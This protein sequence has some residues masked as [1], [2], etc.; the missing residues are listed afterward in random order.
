MR[1]SAFTLLVYVDCHQAAAEVSNM[2]ADV[3]RQNPC[4]VVLMLMVPQ[5]SPPGL[6]A[7]LSAHCHLPVEGKRQICSEQIT[8]EARG[9]VGPELASVVVSLTLSALPIYLWWRAEDFAL[10]PYF[11]Q[12]LRV[13]EQV[14]VD[15][16]RFSATGVD[17]KRL[18]TWLGQHSGKVRLSDLN[19]AR[20]T[21]WRDVLAQCFDSLE[22]RPYLRRIQEVRFEYE[23][24]SPRFAVQRSQSLLLT[25]WLA[26]RLE[27][28]FQRAE[29]RGENLPRTLYFRSDAGEV[30]VE[31]ALRKV[32]GDACGACFSVVLAA[33][34]ARFSF[35]RGTDGK[36]V[37]TLAE[38]PGAVPVSG[39]VRIEVEDEVEILNRELMLLRRDHIYEEVLAL[40]ARM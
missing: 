28:Q 36:V 3:T 8:V 17:L 38:V 6:M 27:W 39:A 5:A 14:I 21:P 11:D 10:P 31:R 2:L 1:A 35:S 24:G 12:I 7:S 30:R 23:L 16:A 22:R 20:T 4:R 29:A 32:D 15:S 40:L 34:D 18:A 33:G 26:T 37:Q 13:T 25:A 9:D 19:W